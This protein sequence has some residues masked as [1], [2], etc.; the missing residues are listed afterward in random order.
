MEQVFTIQ[1]FCELTGYKPQTV[2]NWIYDKKLIYDEDYTKPNFGKNPKKGKGRVLLRA[3]FVNKFIGLRCDTEQS[4]NRDMEK[5]QKSEK[6]QPE[7]QGNIN[8]A[9]LRKR[10]GLN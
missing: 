7:L 10:L 1:K 3:S 8:L 9:Q 5:Q 6:Q 2:Y 4:F